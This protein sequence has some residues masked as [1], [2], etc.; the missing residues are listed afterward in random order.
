MKNVLVTG[1]SGLIGGI[2]LKNNS[3][4]NLYGLD[5]VPSKYPNSELSDISEP[6]KLE[7]LFSKNNIEVVVHLAGNPSVSGKWNSIKVNNIDG[8]SNVF[9]ASKNSGVKKIIFA[10]SNHAVGL[11]ENDNPYDQ[12]I[13]GDY[14]AI[15][16]YELIK[17]D[18]EVRPD[19]LYGVSKAFGENLGRYFH[20]NFGIKVACLRIGSVVKNDSPVRGNSSRFFSTW[21]SHNDIF[22]L[23]EACIASDNLRFN[24]FYGVSNN[25]WK[26]WDISNQKKILDF[27]PQSNAESFRN[28]QF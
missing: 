18:C 2:L 19:S 7:K 16:N 12:I 10:S 4:N 23:I 28:D 25:K 14:N 1:A 13:A 9:E 5:I 20:E 11:Y 3:K 6:Q 21:C 26:I 8:T 17:S 15:E 27:S 24:I 22:G